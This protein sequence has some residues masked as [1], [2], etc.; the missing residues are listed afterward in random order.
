MNIAINLEGLTC[1][2]VCLYTF[3]VYLRYGMLP[4]VYACI[5]FKVLC[6]YTRKFTRAALN[7]CK[8]G[9]SGMLSGMLLSVSVSRLPGDVDE[10]F[11]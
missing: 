10:F 4:A 5:I 9:G 8:S 3:N 11:T 1:C 6:I 2:I 7:T